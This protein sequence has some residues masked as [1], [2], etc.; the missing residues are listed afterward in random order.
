MYT[1]W[2]VLA[3]IFLTVEMFTATFYFLVLAI[4]AVMAG[5]AAASGL[6]LTAQ[7]SIAAA[8]A[9]AGTLGLRRLRKSRKSVPDVGPDIGQPVKVLTWNADGTARVHY[10]GAEWDAEPESPGVARESTFYIKAMQ[11]SRLILTPHRPK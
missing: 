7:Y 2:F 10:R 3:F 11:G 5:V 4:A 1:Y 9:V 8:A 6:G